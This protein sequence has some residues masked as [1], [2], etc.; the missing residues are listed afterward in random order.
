M[1]SMARR[2]VASLAQWF[3]VCHI[4]QFSGKLNV[5]WH[6]SVLPSSRTYEGNMLPEAEI[7]SNAVISRLS[8]IPL[9]EILPVPCFS[10]STVMMELSGQLFDPSWNQLRWNVVFC[11]LLFDSR[12]NVNLERLEF[13]KRKFCCSRS[14]SFD[15][16]LSSQ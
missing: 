12:H 2:T 4:F 8:F 9:I 3:G 5:G 14:F 6:F 1:V 11:N 13:G 7:V 15:K 16:F 10:W